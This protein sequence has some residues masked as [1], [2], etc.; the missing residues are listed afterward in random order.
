MELEGLQRAVS[1]LKKEGIS[2]TEIITDRHL[3]IQKWIRENLPETRHSFD[4]WHIAKG[5]KK[6]LIGI[7]KE[8]D[9]GVVY[10]WVKS[11]TN[12]VYWSAA[13]SKEGDEELIVDKWKSVASH[14][15]NIHHGHGGKF[16]YCQHEELKDRDWL[17]P[18]T[19]ACAK[20]E[21][22]VLSKRLCKDVGKMST[23]HQTSTLEAFHSVINHFAP[24]M[25][26]FSY[27]GQ[28]CRQH[29]A[30]LH[31]NE[32]VNRKNAYTQDGTKKI[33]ISF[34]KFKMDD[35]YSVKPVREQMTFTYVDALIT[36]TMKICT[37][38]K[39][40]DLQTPVPPPLT[41]LKRK[42]CKQEALSQLTS[43]F[44]KIKRCLEEDL[45]VH[46]K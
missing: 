14:I 1:N 42:P 17:K 20:V 11:I 22:V 21:D 38:Q 33:K 19:K 27:N 16:P 39:K 4:V 30:A 18:G 7:A 36:E 26:G 5:I 23:C 6:K 9:C 46:M 35:D 34:P 40:M 13:S 29:I 24:K 2:I 41:A 43:R 28:L 37:H 12:H 10:S 3:Q 44:K 31:F 32:N 8:K 45:K 15:Q 25:N